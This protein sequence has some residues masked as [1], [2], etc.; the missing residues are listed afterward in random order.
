MKSIDAV[1]VMKVL[2]GELTG[3]NDVYLATKILKEEI[4]KNGR[5]GRLTKEEKAK[6]EAAKV[7]VVA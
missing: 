2:N 3:V 7:D 6:R 1:Y 5:K 4:E